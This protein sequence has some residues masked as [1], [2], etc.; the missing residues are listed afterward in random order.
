M[1]RPGIS[2]QE[3]KKRILEYMKANTKPDNQW[4]APTF[5]GTEIFGKE[6]GAASGATSS[7]CQALAL[8]LILERNARG[9]YRLRNP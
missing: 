6:M 4:F 9:H 3:K 1:P 2:K 8:E 5:L 7:A